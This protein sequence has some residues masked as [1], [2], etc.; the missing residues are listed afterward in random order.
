MFSGKTR[1]S[2]LKPKEI[3][4]WVLGDINKLLRQQHSK[5]KEL[6]MESL[7]LHCRKAVVV[8][9]WD[10]NNRVLGVGSIS[11]DYALSHVTAI[12]HNLAVCKG[13]CFETIGHQILDVLKEYTNDADH[14][15][16]FAHD[17]NNKLINVLLTAGFKPWPKGRYKLR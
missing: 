12:I 17:E 5:A 14:V 2:Q 1:T 15:I 10:D 11:K 8:V 9:H 6:S 7:S 13:R 16:A 3:T 4:H